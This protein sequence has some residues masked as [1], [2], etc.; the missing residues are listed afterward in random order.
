MSVPKLAVVPQ[1]EERTPGTLK[2]YDILGE[3]QADGTVVPTRFIVRRAYRGG[4]RP[5]QVTITTTAVDVAECIE[6]EIAVWGLTN[7]DLRDDVYDVTTEFV[8]RVFLAASNVGF[9]PPP[10]YNTGPNGVLHVYRWL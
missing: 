9:V 5:A 6:G 10:G 1:W 4:K 8:E 3:R 2:V 7:K